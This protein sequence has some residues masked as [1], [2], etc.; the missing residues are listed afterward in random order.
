MKQTD[1]LS[2]VLG[3]RRLQ[4]QASHILLGM[5]PSG[6]TTLD[7]DSINP[8]VRYYEC[9]WC[10]AKAGRTCVTKAGYRASQVHSRGRERVAIEDTII[11]HIL[12]EPSAP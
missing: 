2:S 4:Q 11:K 9:D 8:V 12:K 6:M 1:R 10:G 7:N 5:M 3:I